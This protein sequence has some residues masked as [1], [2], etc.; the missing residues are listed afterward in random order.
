VALS[1]LMG[2]AME[3]LRGRSETSRPE[4]VSGGP[5]HQVVK[6]LLPTILGG[7]E[8]GVVETRSCGLGVSPL[9]DSAPNRTQS[10]RFVIVAEVL[11]LIGG[12]PGVSLGSD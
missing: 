2:S 11:S 9:V 1:K 6:H 7:L 4:P 5:Q 10:I 3:V 12:H 8:L